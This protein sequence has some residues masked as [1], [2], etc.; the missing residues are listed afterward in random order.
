MPHAHHGVAVRDTHLTF[1]FA[2]REPVA[3]ENQPSGVFGASG[4]VSPPDLETELWLGGA[5]CGLGGEVAENAI[6]HR[7][8]GSGLDLDVQ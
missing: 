7:G 4:V 5:L 3:F 8:P 1:P 6:Q 2:N